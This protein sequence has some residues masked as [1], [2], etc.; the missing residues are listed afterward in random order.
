MKTVHPVTK[1]A[2]GAGAWVTPSLGI[3]IAVG[4]TWSTE[5]VGFAC[6]VLILAATIGL[7]AYL[8]GA[9]VRY[10]GIAVMWA[11]AIPTVPF[12]FMVAATLPALLFGSFGSLLLWGI[13]LILAVTICKR[14]ALHAEALKQQNAEQACS[15]NG[16]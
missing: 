7:S 16:V 12:A 3:I 15:S 11:T 2:I 10:G 6:F 8:S 14:V 9:C 4:Y 1:L 5:F 13:P